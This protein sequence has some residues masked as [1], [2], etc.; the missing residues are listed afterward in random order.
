MILADEPAASLDPAA[1][2]EVM[3]VFTRVVAA[4][5][6]TLV[7]STHNLDHALGYSGRV[8]G[9]KD[10]RLVLDTPATQLAHGALRELYA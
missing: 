8:L 3:D 5:G 2:E 9:L 6:T 1:G 4:T 7:F 10:G